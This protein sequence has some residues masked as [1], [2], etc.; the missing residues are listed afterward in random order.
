[1]G[2]P[3]KIGS[4]FIIIV[5]TII[6]VITLYWINLA[7]FIITYNSLLSFFFFFSIII[8]SYFYVR[9]LYRLYTRVFHEHYISCDKRDNENDKI[10]LFIFLYHLQV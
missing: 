6:N 5:M 9:V 7:L 3:P 8:V 10:L 4:L 1:M 2:T